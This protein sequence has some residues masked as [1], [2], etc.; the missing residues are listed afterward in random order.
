MCLCISMYLCVSLCVAVSAVY[1]CVYLPVVVLSLNLFACIV[2][3]HVYRPTLHYLL[4]LIHI[5]TALAK[6]YA[7]SLDG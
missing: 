5:Y 7:M 1:L 3:S 4:I 2:I 6:L